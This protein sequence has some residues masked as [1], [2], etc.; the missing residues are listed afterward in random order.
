MGRRRRKG[1]ARVCLCVNRWDGGRAGMSSYGKMA[2]CMVAP[3]VGYNCILM[4]FGR[5]G[6]IGA[7][8]KEGRG[9]GRRAMDM[10]CA[11]D[12]T[13]QAMASGSQAA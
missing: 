8:M 3:I 11:C 9:Q 2:L 12:V 7:W 1:N 4:S 13:G 5:D 6:M 10:C